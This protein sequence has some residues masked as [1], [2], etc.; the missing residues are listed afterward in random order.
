MY[1][2]CDDKLQKSS[3][4][5]NR[6]DAD[7]QCDAVTIRELCESR[8]SYEMIDFLFDRSQLPSSLIIAKNTLVTFQRYHSTCLDC[9]IQ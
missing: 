8:I 3:S 4:V 7:V 1:N 2:I 9:N 5:E 6:L